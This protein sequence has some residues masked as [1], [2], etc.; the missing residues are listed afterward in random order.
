MSRP[1]PSSASSSSPDPAARPSVS[2]SDRE[3]AYLAMVKVLQRDP[4]DLLAWSEAVRTEEGHPLDFETFPFQRELYEAF[5]DRSIP[6]VDIMKSAQCGISAAGVS[7]ALYAPDVWAASV[8]Y[9]LPGFAD[10]YD[11]SDTRV[12]RT[13]DDSVYLSLRVK[14]TD[15][16]GL[17]QV[18]D[19]YAY[20]RGS[21][22]ERQAL[23]IPADV[24]VLDEYDRLD[25]RNIPTFERRLNSPTSLRLQRR[26]SNPSYPE[27]G[28]HLLYLGTDQ[29]QWMVRCWRCGHEA[30]IDYDAGDAGHHHV[31][32]ERGLRVCGR[33]RRELD[34][35]RIASGRW[36]A[37]RPGAGPR[38]YHVSRLIVASEDV[39]AIVAAHHR[40]SE[41]EVQAHYNYDLGQPYSPKGGSISRNQVLAC[42]RDYELPDSYS[43]PSWVTAGVDVGKVLHVRISRW[44][45]DG[46][47]VALFL[48]E[49]P[50]FAGLAQL[51]DRYNVR[52][53][54]IDERPEERAARSFMEAHA[55]RCK[56]VRW[57]GEEQRDPVVVDDDRGLVIARRTGACDRLVAAF[58]TQTKYLPRTLPSDYVSHLTAPHRGVEETKGGQK[59]ARYASSRADDWFF[60]EVY[61]LLAKE[62]AGPP[63]FD[64]AGPAP[65]TI[66]ERIHRRRSF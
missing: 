28:I 27:E 34:P 40:G 22:S 26:F 49:V 19:A 52:F 2:R 4:P 44:T 5:G 25:R 6:T 66:R 24:L 16:K 1:Q 46:Q 10:A 11:F 12:K 63:A 57:S 36:V 13:I 39:P 51:W 37:A 23:S 18:G 61:D 62:S 9:V 45:P 53:G 3:Q 7:L 60:A 33:C 64:M 20:F 47:A 35:E 59:V 15:N 54:L 8:L 41:D 48:G 30:P 29:R 17:R 21:G 32:E 43:G 55:G 56:L 50:D 42:R 38:G 31:D 14:G 65:E 58:S